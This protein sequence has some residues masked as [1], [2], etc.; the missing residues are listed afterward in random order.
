MHTLKSLLGLSVI[1]LVCCAPQEPAVA[2]LAPPPPPEPVAAPPPPEP[3]AEAPA[4]VE[5]TPE[6]AAAFYQGCWAAFNAKDMAKLLACYNDSATSEDVDS[7][8]P[9]ANGKAALEGMVKSYFK[10]FPDQTGELQLVIASGKTVV[11][12]GLIKGTNSGPMPG[13]GGEMPATNKKVGLL[14]GHVIEFQD[15]KAQKE[16]SYMD[17]GTMM[18]QLGVSKGPARKA[19]EKG[20]EAPVVVVATGSDAEKANLELMA[21]GMAAYNAKDAK[22]LE[23]MYADDAILS[24]QFAPQDAVGKKAIMKVHKETWKAFS[25]FK[26]ENTKALA[27]GDYLVSFTTYSGTND[28]P[29]PSMKIWRKTGKPVHGQ[30]L[31]ILKLE[32]GKVKQHWMF[33][34]GMAFAMQL[35]LIEPP[36]PAPKPAAAPLAKPAAPAAAPAAKPAA[37]A[38]AP[39]AAP[40]K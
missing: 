11:G 24:Q 20:V 27:A 13:P 8:M 10:A 1:T 19:I 31:E 30:A 9:P 39:P 2:P 26:I 15:G 40:A 36:K 34:N 16:L 38:P 22:A 5:L 25:D 28:G 18:A 33:A 29:Y 6:Q 23:D 14:M 17:A 7:G 3:V 37:A 4:P 32:N 21:K 12:V 35:G